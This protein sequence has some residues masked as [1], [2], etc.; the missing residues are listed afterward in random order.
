MGGNMSDMMPG[1]HSIRAPVE[2]FSP[3]DEVFRFAQLTRVYD[4]AGELGHVLEGQQY[5]LEA[6]SFMIIEARPGDGPPLHSHPCEVAHIVLAGTA[7]Y[8]L[9]DQRFTVAGPYVVKIPASV[10]H[11]FINIGDQP[12]CLIAAFANKQL[13]R[14][15]LGSNPL[16]ER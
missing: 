4:G 10:P 13:G 9:D 2:P 7:T 14:D 5:G 16:M 8:V 11:T 15:T 3:A 12:L 6:L 1:A